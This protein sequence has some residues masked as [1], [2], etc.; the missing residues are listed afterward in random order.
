MVGRTKSKLVCST[1]HTYIVAAI[2]LVGGCTSN[3]F[4]WSETAN[5]SNDVSVE[6]ERGREEDGMERKKDRPEQKR[7]EWKLKRNETKHEKWVKCFEKP[8][9]II[10]RVHN[11]IIKKIFGMPL[12]LLVFL[13]LGDDDRYECF[14]EWQNAREALGVC[15]C[16]CEWFGWHCFGHCSQSMYE[17]RAEHSVYAFGSIYSDKWRRNDNEK[18][19]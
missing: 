16:V 11:K 12:P 10:R 19:I 8:N 17:W 13:V 15:V 18:D 2:D 7:Q 6:S 1:S 4:K 14:A 3:I 5:N 9:R